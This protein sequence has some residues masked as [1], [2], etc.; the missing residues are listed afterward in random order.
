MP[1]PLLAPRVERGPAISIVMPTFCRA[2]Q[3]GE[4][5]LSLLEGEWSDFELLIRDEGEGLDGTREA[6]AAVC[7]NDKRVRYHQ[8]SDKLGM[9][10]NLNAGI[11]DT[12]GDVIAV[13]HDHDIY[14][15]RF[16]RVMYETLR[17][18]PTANF[19]HCAI[20]VISQKGDYV[21]THNGRWP[22]LT[23]GKKWL[24][25]MLEGLSSPVCALTLVPRQVHE[26]LGLYDPAFGFVADTELWMRLTVEGDVAFVSEPLIKVREREAWHFATSQAV[27]LSRILQGIHEIYIPKAF[28]PCRSLYQSIRLKMHVHLAILRSHAVSYVH[29]ARKILGRGRGIG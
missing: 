13:C 2:H 8:N 1:A 5:V 16:L 6:I 23:S 28:G 22:E 27:T 11:A 12:R 17:R 26:R 20:E 4:S 10:G 15:P 21:Q 25:F 7:G 9:P 18:N 3:I 14:K 19:V 24:R 29:R